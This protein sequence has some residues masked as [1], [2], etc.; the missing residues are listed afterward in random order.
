MRKHIKVMIEQI[1]R[2]LETVVNESN[3]EYLYGKLD[4]YEDMLMILTV[5]GE[6]IMEYKMLLD[7]GFKLSEYHLFNSFKIYTFKNDEEIEIE[8]TYSLTT[9]ATHYEFRTGD[10]IEGVVIKVLAEVD[11]GKVEL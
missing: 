4:A 8:I 3:R 10:I 2:Q 6:Q 5:E 9:H 7:L 11:W 1:K